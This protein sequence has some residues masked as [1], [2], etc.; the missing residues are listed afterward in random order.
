MATLNQDKIKAQQKKKRRFVVGISVPVI[1]ASPYLAYIIDQVAHGHL[2]ELDFNVINALKAFFVFNQGVSILHIWALVICFAWIGLMVYTSVTVEQKAPQV[3]VMKITEDISIPIPA[4]SGQ[5]GNARF[6][7]DAQ[8]DSAFAS[9]TFTGKENLP[10]KKGGFIVEMVKDGNKENI[11]YIG[12]DYHTLIVGSTGC[13]KTRRTLMESF[14]LQIKSGLSLVISDVKGEIYYYTHLYAESQGYK[15]LAFD[16]RN[17]RKSVHYNFLQPIL[18]AFAEGDE[19]KGIDYTWDLVSVLVGE[20]KGEPLW[21]NGE[22]ATIASAILAVVKEAPDDCKNM[23]NVYYFISNMCKPD[24]YGEMPITSYLN[25]LPD[26]HPAKTVFAMAEIAAEKTRASFFTSALG[27]L[28]LFTNP[29]LA[30][31][32]SKSDFK[33]EDLGNEKT[34][35]YMMIPDDKKT[36]YPLVSI[37]ITQMYS[38]QV[39]QANKYGGRLPINV[40]YNLDEIGNFPV[41]PSLPQILAAGRSRGVR[42]NLIIQ[43]FQ[44][45]ESKYEDDFENI[46]SNCRVHVYLMAVSDKTKEEMSKSIGEYTVEVS[47]ASSSASEG[48][49]DNAS[50]SSSASLAGRPLLKPEEVG[51]IKPPYALIK[52]AGEGVA[53]TK[54]P[55]LSQ[56]RLNGMLGL[57]DEEHNIKII[58]ERENAREERTITDIKLWG[59]WHKEDKPEENEPGSTEIVQRKKVIF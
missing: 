2:S 38:I 40:D 34:V 1:L 56:Y 20:S 35:L 26:T 37:L 30:E 31:M 41:I 53:I 54:L 4:G 7:T 49:H 57:G 3:D 43:D 14:W 25:N 12:S 50:F 18:D 39:E 15:T 24:E 6:M 42:A 23:A 5:Y 16:L 10:T 13:G 29:N 46:K 52:L 47:S 44:Q 59:V 36:M 19:A 55:D 11:R 33:L 17:P 8:K 22:T 45:L 51:K 27:T 9:F 32:T 21:Y 48:K 58:M 28:R